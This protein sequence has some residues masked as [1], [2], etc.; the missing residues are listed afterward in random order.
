MPP[1]AR[2]P[3]SFFEIFLVVL[4]FSGWFVLASIQAVIEG[5]PIPQISDKEAL[6]VVIVECLAFP[7]ALAFLWGQGWRAK[8][9]GIDITWLNSFAGVLLFGFSILVNLILWEAIGHLVGGKEFLKQ[10]SQAISVSLPLVLLLSVLNG[11]FEEFFLCRYLVEA[12]AKYGPAVAVGVS[13][14]VRIMYHLYQGPLG[15]VLVLA[16]GIVVTAFYW[17]FR[18]VWPS[19]LAHI[20]AD[21][22][23]LA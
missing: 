19:M 11:I 5:F 18:Q 15:A 22:A 8:D 2:K 6:S 13:A 1:V 7:A 14:F 21:V 4:V 12:F 23:A 10:F 17:R 20:L 16:F 3:H 9:L